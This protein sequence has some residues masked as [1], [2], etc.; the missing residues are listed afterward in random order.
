ME[1][2]ILDDI[3]CAIERI[4]LGHDTNVAF[5][6]R[7]MRARIDPIDEHRARCRSHACSGDA[8]RGRL[9]G[10]IWTEE[11]EYFAIFDHKVDPIDRVRMG[12]GIA[13]DHIVQCKW[14][15]GTLVAHGRM[16]TGVRTGIAGRGSA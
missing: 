11:P 4:E 10:A 16:L 3:A 5:D 1:I 9:A 13:F 6:A 2:E 12:S 15:H 14:V 8:D 7:R